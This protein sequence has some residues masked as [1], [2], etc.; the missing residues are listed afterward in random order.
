M[1]VTFSPFGSVVSTPKP[2]ASGTNFS[3]PSQQTVASAPVKVVATSA[4][5]LNA[6]P[7]VS[8]VRYSEG[9]PLIL[10]NMALRSDLEATLKSLESA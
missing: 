5:A 4:V 7:D 2:E 3:V 1:A 8:K 6:V 9:L 10:T